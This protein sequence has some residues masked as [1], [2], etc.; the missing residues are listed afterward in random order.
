M[1]DNATPQESLWIPDGLDARVEVM[2]ARITAEGAEYM[3]NLVAVAYARIAFFNHPDGEWNTCSSCSTYGRVYY[4]S[5]D[6]R[7]NADFLAEAWEQNLDYKFC[8]NCVVRKAQMRVCQR[9]EVSQFMYNNAEYA[10]SLTAYKMFTSEDMPLAT[11]PEPLMCYC[12]EYIHADHER[13]A[14]DVFGETI[15]AHARC[16]MRCEVCEG[17]FQWSGEGRVVFRQIER[18]AHCQTCADV[19]LEDEEYTDC[20]RCN[21]Y[22]HVDSLTY[23]D[24]RERNLCD[25]CYRQPIEC[26]ECD[27]HYTEGNDHECYRNDGDTIYSYTYKPRAQF[28][29]AGKYHLGFEL[30]VEE[31][32]GNDADNNYIASLIEGKLRDR[33]Y[34][35]YDGSLDAGFEVVTHP[36][37]LEEYHNNFDWSFLSTLVSGNFVSW[38]NS[39]C[40]F[41][42]HISRKAFDAPSGYQ[43]EVSHKMRFTKFIYDNQY[44]VER[45]AGRKANDYASF[46]DKGQIL[47]KVLHNDQRNGRYEV[48]NVYNDHTYEIRI[49]KGSLR[50]ARLLSN[51]EFVH[52]VCEY[53][54]NMKV[55]AKHTP[56]AWSRFV[57]FVTDNEIQYPNLMLIID[58]A[59]ASERI[60]SEV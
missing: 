29:G 45:I 47:R 48:V 40:G 39:N 53:T 7:I 38:N 22:Y 57:K 41:H 36:H 44:Q 30:E 10:S 49:F 25:Y 2:K 18:Q 32:D 37:T 31:S 34:M 42:V 8:Y 9:D 54:R 23:S 15:V 35:K 58:E 27:Y 60:R 55:V 24:E 11:Q 3:D 20:E 50:K 13:Q 6:R 4:Y 21:E 52:A 19:K 33:V 28:F 43:A 51:I 59:F 56:F 26:P 1:T 14:K 12:G 17:N 46:G 5:Q 16:I